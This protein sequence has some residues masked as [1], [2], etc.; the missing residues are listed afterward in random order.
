MNAMNVT[1][2]RECLKESDLYS[3]TRRGCGGW[4]AKR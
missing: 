4:R 1:T 2:F 3:V